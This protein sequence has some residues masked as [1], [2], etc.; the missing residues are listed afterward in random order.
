MLFAF[1]QDSDQPVNLPSLISLRGLLK[2]AKALS[3]PLSG[4]SS[5]QAELSLCSSQQAKP[6]LFNLSHNSR[7]RSDQNHLGFQKNRHMCT[8]DSEMFVRT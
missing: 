3:N 7:N 2:K 8:V 1:S 4:D 6:K 5:D